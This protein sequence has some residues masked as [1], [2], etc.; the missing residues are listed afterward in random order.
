MVYLTPSFNIPGQKYFIIT[1]IL[2]IILLFRFRENVPYRQIKCFI[3]YIPG[4]LF[5][6]LLFY[7]FQAIN[8]LIG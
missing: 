7:Y 5:I 6:T 3:I 4:K 8:V 1:F 2:Y